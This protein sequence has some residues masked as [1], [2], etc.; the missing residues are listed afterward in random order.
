MER[1][2]IL[3]KNAGFCFG[4]KRAVDEA[5][6][7]QKEFGKKIYTLGP[8]IHNNDVVNYLENNDIF[9]IELSDA[10]SLKKGL[11][12]FTN[13]WEKGNLEQGFKWNSKRK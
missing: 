12:S 7:Y 6:K 13:Y 1:N 3:A 8:L 5:I 11:C 2:V 4:V 9:A 10:D